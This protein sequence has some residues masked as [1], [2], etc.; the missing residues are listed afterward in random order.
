ML[1][2]R[3][4]FAPAILVCQKC[5][6]EF[7]PIQ[8][9]I[10]DPACFHSNRIPSDI[11]FN[12]SRGYL[13]VADADIQRYDEE[14]A[15]LTATL[16]SLKFH[17]DIREQDRQ[18][19]K[20]L[21]SPFRRIPNEIWI[22]IFAW[23]MTGDGSDHRLPQVC[24]RWREILLAA[25]SLWNNIQIDLEESDSRFIPS[26][27]QSR[28]NYCRDIPLHLTIG[29]P[30]A[31]SNPDYWEDDEGLELRTF[32]E[33]RVPVLRQLFTEVLDQLLPTTTNLHLMRFNTVWLDVVQ[34]L[35]W[36]KSKLTSF[37]IT[38]LD[39][40]HD[41]DFH[42]A[43]DL[44]AACPDLL[45]LTFTNIYLASAY[46]SSPATP[47]SLWDQLET[48]R[49]E[50]SSVVFIQRFLSRASSLRAITIHRPLEVSGQ[51]PFT[52]LSKQLKHVSIQDS[53]L[54]FLLMHTTIPSLTSASI[55]YDR[56]SRADRIWLKQFAP[57]IHRSACILQTLR[58]DEVFIDDQTFI[59]I[60]Q[61]TPQLLTLTFIPICKSQR[62]HGYGISGEAYKKMMF[63]NN[64]DKAA[65]LVPHLQ[66]LTAF[67]YP[68]SVAVALLDMVASRLSLDSRLQ[69]CEV[70]LIRHFRRVPI[71]PD[72]VSSFYEQV[73]GMRKN[74]MRLF[75]EVRNQ[76]FTLP[77]V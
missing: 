38:K 66:S 26:F 24:S 12:D 73:E 50:N 76:E 43:I 74:G 64:M 42:S 5:N 63:H 58:L 71:S 6:H 15:S 54:L 59:D 29:F 27:V 40:A 60:L 33:F 19:Y 61:E 20:A 62:R 37:A 65:P 55:S 53:G 75:A 57:F 31:P 21:A 28:R 44:L 35:M 34:P 30:D 32:C 39:E 72:E 2:S 46:E 14:I 22:Q 48:V 51:D 49:Y 16:K 70:G 1:G 8:R 25:P 47:A 77:Q 68:G 67:A 56:G 13:A 52:T 41:D 17:R 3:V 18:S 10:L 69:Y 45:H 9:T 11:D 36:M 4:V 7:P 23:S